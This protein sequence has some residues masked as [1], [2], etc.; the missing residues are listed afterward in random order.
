M[1]QGKEVL[2]MRVSWDKRYIT[3]GP[4]CTVF[5]LAFHLFDRTACSAT[6]STSASPVRWCPTTTRADTGR[7]FPLNAMFMNGPTRGKD[8]FMP[9]DSSSAARRWPARA[10]AC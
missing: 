10:G 4:V 7:H 3:L 2:G 8:V 6:R 5:G 9:L 1:Y